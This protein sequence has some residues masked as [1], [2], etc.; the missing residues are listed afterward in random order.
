M[1][2]YIYSAMQIQQEQMSTF[3]VMD[4]NT[5]HIFMGIAVI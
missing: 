5:I 2:Q 4:N 3:L 1:L